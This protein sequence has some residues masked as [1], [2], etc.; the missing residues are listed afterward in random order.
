MP[1]NPPSCSEISAPL[2]TLRATLNGFRNTDDTGRLGGIDY[3]K[4]IDDILATAP[5]LPHFNAALMDWIVAGVNAQIELLTDFDNI[6]D[7]SYSQFARFGSTSWSACPN[8]LRAGNTLPHHTDNP[9]KRTNNFFPAPN[10][11]GGK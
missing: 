10:F 7:L 8:L 4:V 11:L 2:N 6:L 5:R 1:Q 9:P 3:D